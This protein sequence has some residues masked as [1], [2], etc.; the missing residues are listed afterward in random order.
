MIIQILDCSPCVLQE[1]LD[2]VC[3]FEPVYAINHV[4]TIGIISLFLS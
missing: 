3:F 4:F 1:N 2:N